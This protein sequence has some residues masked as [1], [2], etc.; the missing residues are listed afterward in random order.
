[1]LVDIVLGVNPSLTRIAMAV[2]GVMLA[3]QVAAKAFRDATFL[4]AWPVAALPVMTVATAVLTG[5]LVHVASRLSDRYSPAVVVAC[6]FGLSAVGHVI[7]WILYDAGRW[8]AV[9]IYLHLAGV[10]RAAALGVLGAGR[11]TLRPCRGASRLRPHRRRGHRR[12][13]G[14]QLR[15]R[16]HRHDARSA[17]GARAAG[18]AACC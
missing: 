12:R 9:V 5:L 10:A 4:T 13:P 2:W 1:M 6:G 11:G 7:E 15:R 16:T 8:S 18:G 14:R 3:H 17:I